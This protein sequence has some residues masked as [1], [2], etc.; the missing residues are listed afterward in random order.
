MTVLCIWLFC[1]LITD[2]LRVPLCFKA[3]SG[4][5]AEG[6]WNF[7]SYFRYNDYWLLGFGALRLCFWW[8]LQI[9]WCYFSD[10]VSESLL[11]SLGCSKLDAW[12]DGSDFLFVLKCWYIW[13][14]LFK[15]R[16]LMQHFESAKHMYVIPRSIF[17]FLLYFLNITV[18][19]VVGMLYGFL[20]L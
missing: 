6:A 12:I 8:L 14:L 15:W 5:T 16:D 11:L 19:L 10:L 9:S 1:A 2:Y 17:E 7:E 3:V 18:E 13:F 4:F 20:L